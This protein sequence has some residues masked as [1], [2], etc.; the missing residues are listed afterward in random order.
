MSAD[1]KSIA[2]DLTVGSVPR[3]LIRFA[4]PL[5]A[6][7]LLQIVYNMV[8]AAVVGKVVG[9]EA[10]AGVTVGSDLLNTATFLAS[11]FASAGQIIISQFVGAGRMDKVKRAIG[12]LFTFLFLLAVI[13]TGG[14]LLFRDQILVLLNTPAEA[15][16]HAVAYLTPCICGMV[17]ITGYNL[18]SS[19]LRG[20]G[21]SRRP[22]V[23]IAI[24]SLLNVV[25]DLLFVAGFHWDAFGAALATV[26]SQAVSFILAIVY[27]YRRREAFGFDFKRESFRIYGDVFGPI[28]KLGIPLVLQSAAISMSRLFVSAN[29]NSYG[30]MATAVTGIGTKLDNTINIFTGSFSAAGGAMIGQCIGGE[31]YERVPKVIRSSFFVDLGITSVLAAILVFFPN[32]VFGLFSSDATTIEMCMAY[33]PVALLSFLASVVRSPFFSLISGS[34][35]APL[36]LVVGIVDGVVARVG[37]SLILGE[38]LGFGITGYWYGAALAGFM[39][40]VIGGIYFLTG[41]WKTRKNVMKD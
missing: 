25:L 13:V 39:P 18:V 36:N 28:V 22:F 26:M 8:D 23:F 35:N 30:Y 11:G 37:F 29:I 31:K 32:L 10:L 15:W 40:F 33:I 3:Q 17:F 7:G 20:M 1:K 41:R 38:V 21:D 2:H 34:G 9:S 24:A 4:M 19:I 6:S 16:D 27:L 5:V 12:T 14:L